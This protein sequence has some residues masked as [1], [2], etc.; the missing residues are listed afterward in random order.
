M[1]GE[2]IQDLRTQ[3]SELTTQIDAYKED[4]RSRGK[5]TDEI[6]VRL[7]TLQLSNSKLLAN[8]EAEEASIPKPEER[9]DEDPF[10]KY[11]DKHKEE[12]LKRFEEA[13]LEVVKKQIHCKECEAK[14]PSQIVHQ[15]DL[16]KVQD[17]STTIADNS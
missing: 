17:G 7:M 14:N 13:Y 2:L 4:L 10:L 12:A 5:V 15:I 9:K 3:I 16:K 6:L 1:I 8:L 11:C